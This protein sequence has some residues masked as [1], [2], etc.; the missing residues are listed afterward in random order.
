MSWQRPLLNGWLRLVEKRSLTHAASPGVIRRRLERNARFFFHG[1][2]EVAQRWHDLG[3]DTALW[4]EPAEANCGNIVLY[5]HGGGYV[6]GSPRTHA[7]MVSV[8]A[9]ASGVRAVLPVYPLAPEHPFPAAL[10]R[11][12]DAYHALLA[13]GVSADHIVMGGDSAGGG[14]VLALLAR[15]IAAGADL[16]RGV[17][18][19]SPLTDLTFSGASLRVNADREAVLPAGRVAELA[20]GYLADTAADD[21]RVSPLFADFTGAPPVWITVGDTEI[22]LDD[23]RRIVPHMRAQGVRVQMHIAHDLPHVWPMFHNMLP[24]ARATLDNLAGWINSRWD[25]APGS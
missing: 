9:K 24:E 18:A 25:A 10:D 2:R 1:P 22:L 5:F 8:L 6:F 23:A 3:A 20:A 7:A 11:A 17:F 15:L 21:P 19:F 16:P 13:S 14:L 4:L 12:E